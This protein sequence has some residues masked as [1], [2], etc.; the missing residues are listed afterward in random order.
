M[1]KGK[2]KNQVSKTNDTPNPE[3]RRTEEDI[4]N[5]EQEVAHFRDVWLNRFRIYRSNTPFLIMPRSCCLS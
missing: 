4:R 3:E 5:D 1:P 2:K